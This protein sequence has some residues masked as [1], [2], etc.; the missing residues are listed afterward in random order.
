MWVVVRMAPGA[1]GGKRLAQGR[2]RSQRSGH[3]VRILVIWARG[4]RGAAGAVGVM[5]GG[6]RGLLQANEVLAAHRGAV[7]AENRHHARG[8]ALGGTGLLEA[9]G[10]ARAQRGP[11]RREGGGA[12]ACLP[13][14]LEV[15]AA[16]G[17]GHGQHVVALGV[18]AVA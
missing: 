1:V 16:A 17:L 14:V 6:G 7:R 8:R 4:A 2:L 3:A 9:P 18:E 15:E 5:A 11:W 10:A 13:L 12:A